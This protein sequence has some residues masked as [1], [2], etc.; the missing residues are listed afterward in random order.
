MKPSNLGGGP[1]STLIGIGTEKVGGVICCWTS[2]LKNLKV[3]NSVA[4]GHRACG[5]PQVRPN[6]PRVLRRNSIWTKR[7]G[8]LLSF[9]CSV[10]SMLAP[11]QCLGGQVSRRQPAAAPALVVAIGV[12]NL[13]VVIDRAAKDL[14]GNGSKKKTKGSLLFQ[15]NGV[16]GAVFD[17]SFGKP[18]ITLQRR[19]L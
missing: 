12:C 3:K 13:V 6:L 4:C 16:K 11:R 7:R 18:A 15:I 5:R 14:N 17:R 10:S 2:I 1:H 19:T 8:N 9:L